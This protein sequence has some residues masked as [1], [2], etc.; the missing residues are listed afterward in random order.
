MKKIVLLVFGIVLVVSVLSFFR[1]ASNRLP[2]DTAIE[3][4]WVRD[5]EAYLKTSACPGERKEYEMG[6]GQLTPLLTH[7]TYLGVVTISY[8]GLTP[9]SITFWDTIWYL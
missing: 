6:L 2:Y 1:M 5:Q 3:A 9:M 4:A 7:K 8:E